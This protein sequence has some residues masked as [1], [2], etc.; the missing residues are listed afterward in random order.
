MRGL[1]P[2]TAEREPFAL[3]PDLQLQQCCSHVIGQRQRAARAFRLG[4]VH[5]VVLAWLCSTLS[6]PR[7]LDQA[8]AEHN[9][10][11][12]IYYDHYWQLGQ[13]ELR[14]MATDRDAHRYLDCAKVEQ[15]RQ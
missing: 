13:Q 3:L 10:Q 7:Q 9:V 1:V 12:Q 14:E 15:P 2:G 8:T 5:H 4:I 6:V 11:Q